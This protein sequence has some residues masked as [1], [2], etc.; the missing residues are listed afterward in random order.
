MILKEQL[1]HQSLYFLIQRCQ[2]FRLTVARAYLQEMVLYVKGKFDHSIQA[3][4]TLSHYHTLMLSY[5]IKIE[6]KIKIK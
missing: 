2:F 5:I 1:H 3:S 4:N 6:I